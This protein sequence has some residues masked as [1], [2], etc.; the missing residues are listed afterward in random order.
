[1]SGGV[2][3]RNKFGN[4]WTEYTGKLVKNYTGKLVKIRPIAPGASLSPGWHCY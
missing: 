4:K 2:K 3:S 1:M